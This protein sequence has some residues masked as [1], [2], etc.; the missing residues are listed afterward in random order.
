MMQKVFLGVLLV[1]IA[2]SLLSDCIVCK[3]WPARLRIV[4]PLASHTMEH[5][6]GGEA[7]PTPTTATVPAPAPATDAPPKLV[8]FYVT[9]CPVARAL[10]PELDKLQQALL[11]AH[12][13][14]QRIDAEATPDAATAAGVDSFPALIFYKAGEKTAYDGELTADAIKRF[15]ELS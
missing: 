15:I 5:F 1:T 11:G 14:I 12:I 7:G 10:M 6:D 13:D 4:N 9:W 3:Y 8:I 2:C